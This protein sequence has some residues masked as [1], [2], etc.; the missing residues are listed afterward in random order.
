MAW[1]TS[2]MSML[3][4]LVQR[5]RSLAVSQKVD[6]DRAISVAV[7]ELAERSDSEINESELQFLAKQQL[8]GFGVLQP[9]LDDPAIEEIWINRPNQIH[10][11]SDNRWRD[12]A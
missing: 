9:Y 7:D 11:Y 8:V 12:L 6:V 5:A 3:G 10:F 1:K 2:L 4:E